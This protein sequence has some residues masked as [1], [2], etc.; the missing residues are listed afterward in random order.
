MRK[1]GEFSLA[2]GVRRRGE[3]ALRL[4]LGASRS[5]IAWQLTVESVS[6]VLLGSLAGLVLAYC[7]D[8]VLLTQVHNAMV[9]FSLMHRSTRGCWLLLWPR[10]YSPE[11]DLG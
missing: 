5:S 2:R 7:A 6:L 4:A 9:N 11:S 10:R 8:R 3:I 1:P